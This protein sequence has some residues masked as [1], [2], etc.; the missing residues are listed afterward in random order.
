[1]CHAVD[2]TILMNQLVVCLLIDEQFPFLSFQPFQIESIFMFSFFC[3]CCWSATKL[4]VRVQY[5]SH[6]ALDAG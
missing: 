6:I 5:V 4:C 2:Y 1:M 3:H